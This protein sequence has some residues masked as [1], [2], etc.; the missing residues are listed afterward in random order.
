MAI[1]NKA[2]DASEQKVSFIDNFGAS[3]ITGQTLQIGPIPFPCTLQAVIAT[4]QGAAAT[5]SSSVEVA[6]FIP[7]TGFTTI[8]GLGAS[9]VVPTFGTSGYLSVSLVSSGSSLLNLIAGDMVQF[10][11]NNGANY[12]VFEV[13]V[14]KTQDIVSHFG[15]AT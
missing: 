12:P 5:S 11:L 1:T 2:L 3:I 13:V 4:A 10:R 15:S 7:G 9:F 8:S 14:K 6:R